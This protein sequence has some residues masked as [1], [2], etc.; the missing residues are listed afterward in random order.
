M[1]SLHLQNM[2]LII[3]D[4]DGTIADTSEGIIDSHKFTLNNMG[5]TIPSDEVLRSVIGGNLLKTYIEKFCFEESAARKAVGIY[6]ERYAEVGIHKALLYPGFRK[7]LRILK[8][9]SFKI[10]V[11]TLKTESFARIMLNEMG[12]DSY[13][14]EIC[15]MDV[16]DGLD[17]GG[18]IEKCI[19][20][21][22]CKKEETVLVGDS[23]NDLFGAK[24]AGVNFIGVTY[25][26]GFTEDINNSFITAAS[27]SEIISIVLS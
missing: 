5:R 22:G 18:L 4:F 24:D 12:I 7:V 17:K 23:N 9:K 27:P 11:A 26:F 15:G 1:K 13:F 10:G 19:L 3:F 14:D 6:R 8:D 2:K 25:G 20:L 16:N 21:C